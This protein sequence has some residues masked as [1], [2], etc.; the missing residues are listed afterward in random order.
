MKILVDLRA[1]LK[2]VFIED[3]AGFVMECLYHIKKENKDVELIFLYDQHI[4]SSVIADQEKIVFKKSLRGKIGL[5]IW[6]N[7]VVPRIAKKNKADLFFSFSS[8]SSS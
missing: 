1:F 6:Y 7:W 2:S 3:A 4:D 5:K 8:L